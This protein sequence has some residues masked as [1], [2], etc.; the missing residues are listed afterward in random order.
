M[1]SLSSLT[2]LLMC[3]A[4]ET[5]LNQALTGDERG[6]GDDGRGRR[7]L[8]ASVG[9]LAADRLRRY[10]ARPLRRLRQWL[11]RDSNLVWQLLGKRVARLRS[12]PLH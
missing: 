5:L 12:S 7:E 6:R 1:S 10:R 2:G 3:G 9:A 4:L 8:R 11:W